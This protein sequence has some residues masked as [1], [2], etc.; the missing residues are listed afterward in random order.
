L[1]IT[2]FLCTSAFCQTNLSDD[3]LA[4]I[5]FIQNLNA[6]IPTQL[7][8]RDETGQSVQLANYFGKKPVVMVLGYYEC[9]MLCNLVLNGMIESMQDL[10]WTIGNQFDVV[11]ISIDPRETPSLAS[12]KKRACLKR[13][14]RDQ[15][16]AGWHFLTGNRPAINEIARAVGFQY[17]YDEVAKQYAHPSGFVVLTP[18]GKISRYFFGVTFS[19]REL[20]AALEAASSRSIGS[21]IQDFVLLCFHYRPITSKYGAAIMLAVRSLA[22]ATVTGLALLIFKMIRKEKALPPPATSEDER[23]IALNHSSQ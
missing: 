17:A 10:R 7:T 15:A 18:D 14:G 1:C 21:R 5:T 8:F 9:P 23:P 13:Y 6:Q 16:A 2:F 4:K 11:N 3:A 20:H 22:I 19:A 12:A